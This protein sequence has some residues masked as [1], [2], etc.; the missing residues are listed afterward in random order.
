MRNHAVALIKI[1]D[2]AVRDRRASNA[3]EKYEQARRIRESLNETAPQDLSI[4]YDLAEVWIKIGDAT[5][6]SGTPAQALQCYTRSLEILERLSSTFTAHARVR[7][8]LKEVYSR[9]GEMNLAIAS[10]N[11]LPVAKRVEH[12]RA[13]RPA[14]KR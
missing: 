11:S 8:M 10:D 6:L 2:I 12:L 5:Q 14:L 13:A 3:I 7:D 4:R 1:G 9:I